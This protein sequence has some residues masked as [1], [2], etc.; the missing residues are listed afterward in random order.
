MAMFVNLKFKVD[1]FFLFTYNELLVF[2]L[3][4]LFTSKKNDK[5]IYF[6]PVIQMYY[7]LPRC[8]YLERFMDL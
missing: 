6:K 4:L 5:G 2:L 7:F 3:R 1:F 8:S